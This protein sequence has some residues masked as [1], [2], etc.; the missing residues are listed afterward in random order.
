MTDAEQDH[1]AFQRALENAW[2]Q[3]WDGVDHMTYRTEDGRTR[4]VNEMRW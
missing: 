4:I 3:G 1:A 2:R